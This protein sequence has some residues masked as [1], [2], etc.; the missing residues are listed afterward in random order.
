MAESHGDP[1]GKESPDQNI[2]VAASYAGPVTDTDSVSS[3]IY[4]PSC[5]LCLFI[6]N[7]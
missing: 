4:L 2:P 6:K 3:S 1:E 5:S 7:F